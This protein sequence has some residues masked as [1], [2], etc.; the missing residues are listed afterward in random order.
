[1]TTSNKNSQESIGSENDFG[2]KNRFPNMNKK[3]KPSSN[4]KINQTLGKKQL[5]KIEEESN[6]SFIKSRMAF[7]KV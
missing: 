5:E 1:M 3:F 6:A 4:M 2:Y 7:S